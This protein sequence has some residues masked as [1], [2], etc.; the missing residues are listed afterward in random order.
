MYGRLHNVCVALTGIALAPASR[1]LPGTAL[2]GTSFPYPFPDRRPPSAP[3]PSRRVA[4][5]TIAVGLWLC[6]LR[7]HPHTV[8]IHVPST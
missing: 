3:P 1:S 4:T 6:A 8:H 2:D 7:R 5:L